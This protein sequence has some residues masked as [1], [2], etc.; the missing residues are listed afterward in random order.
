[1]SSYDQHICLVGK[2]FNRVMSVAEVLAALRWPADDVMARKLI[3]TAA[4]PRQ[5]RK[6]LR[7]LGLSV[8]VEITRRVLERGL[9]RTG[10]WTAPEV[11]CGTT[12]SGVDGVAVAGRS[13]HPGWRH[14][15]AA[16][17]DADRAALL[18]AC[19]GCEHVYGDATTPAV[20]GGA[21]PADVWTATFECGPN[22]G[23]DRAGERATVAPR[24]D[25]LGALD[26]ALGYVRHHLCL[27]YTSPSP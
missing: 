18:L 1:M 2:G 22:S 12:F 9:R 4:E 27:L 21:P 19:G 6:V 13:L 7:H 3:K 8:N 20:T 10:L 25:N 16:E 23:M 17:T 5:H 26:M 11:R 15:F 24:A 14:I